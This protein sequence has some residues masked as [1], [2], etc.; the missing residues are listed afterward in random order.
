[1]VSNTNILHHKSL[2]FRGIKEMM[3]DVFILCRA[4][5]V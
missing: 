5:K 2:I 4:Y 1:M 3:K